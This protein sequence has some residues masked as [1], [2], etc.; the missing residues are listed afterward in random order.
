MDER[1]AIDN[2][3]MEDRSTTMVNYQLFFFVIPGARLSRTPS[4]SGT[5]GASLRPGGGVVVG[6]GMGSKLLAGRHR[7]LNPGPPA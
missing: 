4:L 1:A 7:D 2:N 3:K 6:R 5:L